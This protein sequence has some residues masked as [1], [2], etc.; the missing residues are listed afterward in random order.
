[1][2]LMETNF[3][4]KRDMENLLNEDLLPTMFILEFINEK[5]PSI[6]LELIENLTLGQLSNLINIRN[7][8][9]FRANLY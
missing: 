4:L 1:M 2:N 7:C 8:I 9:N 5:N 3:M 6:Q